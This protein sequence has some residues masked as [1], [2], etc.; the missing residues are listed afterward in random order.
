[1]PIAL[2]TGGA[3]FIGSHLVDSLVDDG[4]DVRVVDDLSTGRRENLPANVKLSVGDVLDDGLMRP[5]VAAADEVYHLAAIASVQKCTEAYE[6]SHQVNAVAAIKI[7]ELLRQS[8]A[9]K[10]VYASSAAVYGTAA[11]VPIVETCRTQ[12]ISIYGADK[13]T[14]EIHASAVF[15][16]FGISSAGLRFFNVYGPRQDPASPYSGVI[17]RFAYAIPR[18]ISLEVHGDGQQTRDFVH[19][20]DVVRALRLAARRTEVPGATVHNICTGHGTSILELVATLGQ[21][22]SVVPDVRFGPARVGDIRTS[23]G[24]ADS[25]GSTL[26]FRAKVPL[27]DGLADL[28]ASGG[29]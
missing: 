29:S 27:K 5:L 26:G 8:P 12:P 15:E 4:Y 10:F 23:I 20:S 14:M 9:K 3:G 7:F 21:I 1:M 13:L 17:S 19:V 18:A 24:S 22:F 25:S 28:L 2:V 16:T 11:Q 6:R